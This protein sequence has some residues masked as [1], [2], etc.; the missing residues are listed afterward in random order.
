M[1]KS[2]TAV[3]TAPVVITDSNVSRAWSRLLL[4][5]INGA[6]T[7]VA[8]LTLSVGGG[9]DG[10]ALAED[11]LVRTALDRLLERK[12]RRSVDDVA[13]TI[14]PQRLWAICATRAQLFDLYIA[15]LP[16]WQALN[17][18]LNRRG[19][20]FERM[21]R[22]GRGPCDG[23]Q[24]EWVLSQYASR[25]GIRRSMLQVAIFD[26]ERDHVPDAQLGFPCLQ[27]ISFEP[28]SAGLVVN[29]FYATQQ[30]FDKAYGNY[31]G[32]AQLGFFMAQQMQMRLARL[33]VVAG[34]AK[35]ERIAKS[36]PHFAPVVAAA[37]AAMCSPG[38][39][40]ATVASPAVAA[41]EAAS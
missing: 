22:Y 27:Q 36:D 9:P 37:T 14:F 12:G 38:A 17:R 10:S 2:T 8:P 3:A 40:S 39:L 4:R 23:N 15:T 21:V 11:P 25:P 7:E 26:P 34:I 29:A 28:T 6:G 5:V 35:L 18:R 24:L 20:Y 41:L 31:I 13:F 32:L 19:L 33:N 16:R 30:I 1:S